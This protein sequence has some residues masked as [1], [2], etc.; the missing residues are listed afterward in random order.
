MGINRFWKA[1][2]LGP[3][4]WLVK[5]R[6]ILFW[7]I[8][9]LGNLE[10]LRKSTRLLLGPAPS[11]SGQLIFPR[12]PQGLKKSISGRGPRP[13]KIIVGIDGFD[14]ADCGYS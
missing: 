4:I 9:F 8:I 6:K 10:N 11:S 12:N 13:K 1:G 14:V 2:Q 7:G 3:G 5:S